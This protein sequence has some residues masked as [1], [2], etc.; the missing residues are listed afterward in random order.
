MDALLLH[1]YL[2]KPL[3]MWLGFLALILVLV[4]IDLGG[5]NR[6]QEEI[7]VRK[8]LYLSCFYIALS[9]LFGLWIWAQMGQESALEYYTGYVIEK[10]L[11]MDNLFVMSVIF[12]ALSIPRRYQHRVLFWGILGVI[13]L[14]GLMIGLGAALLHQFEWVLYLFAAFL[15]VTGMKLLFWD[16][17]E[18]DHED[19]VKHNP[20][21]RY[22]R[23]R[24]KIT[25]TIHEQRFFVRLPTTENTSRSVLYMTPLFLALVT[26]EFADVIFA[27]DSV[28]A[29]FA[30][31][32]DT[33]IVFTSNIFAILGLRALYFTLSAAIERFHYLKYSVAAV[34]VFI[35][36]K[37]F[38]PIITPLEKIPAV[39]SL[40]ITLGLILFGAVYSLIKTKP[41][42]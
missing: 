1:N 21:I 42:Q 9:L 13:M 22:L 10:S 27:V 8:S 38:I 15:I 17:G 11:S 4:V 23:R 7:G 16:G 19:T 31:T 32:T 20:I 40:S 39:F 3:W 30:I 34:L 35:G 33:Y 28:P 6:R 36:A 26:I 14:R 24:F 37:V 29:V 2:D 5:F 25:E 12:G 18:D 41:A